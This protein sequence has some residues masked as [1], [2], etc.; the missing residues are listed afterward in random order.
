M[1]DA[2]RALGAPQLAGTWVNRKG[3]AKKLVA[4]VAGRELGGAVGSVAAERMAGRSSG[5]AS[6]MPDFGRQ[7]YVAVSESHV[8]LVK[9]KQ[10]L[11]KVKLT[12]ETHAIA[13]RSE[14]VGAELGSGKIACPLTITFA[15]GSQ[16]E[17]DV[18]RGV[19]GAAKRVVAVLSDRPG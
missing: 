9:A 10:G 4:S 11:W 7:A 3:S 1:P 13:P 14:V 16:W 19:K 12:E 18:P 5:G 6:D 15:S 17:L 2:S 8:A